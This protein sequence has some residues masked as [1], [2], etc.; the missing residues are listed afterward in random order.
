MRHPGPNQRWS[1][2]GKDL[3]A[4]LEEVDYGYLLL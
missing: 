1:R 4:F 3:F 2:H